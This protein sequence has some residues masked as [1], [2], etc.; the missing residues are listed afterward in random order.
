MKKVFVYCL[1]LTVFFVLSICA[2]AK[3]KEKIKAVSTQGI[4]LEQSITKT[5]NKSSKQ[6]KKELKTKN[7]N[8]KKYLKNVSQIKKM[9]NKKRI[10]E[11]N[12]EFYNKRLNIK[13]NKLKEFEDSQIEEKGENEL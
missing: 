2:D 12:L 11:R 1:V 8:K 13:T 4:E 7:K 3:N 5:V 6:E 10:K 9:R